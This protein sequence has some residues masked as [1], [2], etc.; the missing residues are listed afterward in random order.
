MSKEYSV[1]EVEEILKEHQ[2]FFESH[3]T[4]GIEFRLSQ[5]QKL[6]DSII[7][8]EGKITEALQQDL[9]KH[10]F[11]TYT[12]EV[13]FVLK[14]IT[15]TMK[16]L[17]SW[18]KTKRVKT[19]LHFQPGKSQIIYEPYGT[20]LII[21]PFN[22]PFQLLIEPLV[23]AIAAGNCAVLKPSE[24]VPNVS[25]V[26]SE[27][28]H[29]T[30]DDNYIRTIEGGIET[31]QSLIHA[32]FDYIFFTGSIPVGKI[33]ME[34]AAKNLVPVTLEL[35]GKSP[36]IVDRTA[37]IKAAAS[38]IMW[39]KCVNSGQT[40]V[41]PDYLLIH[42]SIKDELI[43]EL[44]E[45]INTFYGETVE[46]SKHYGR[47]VT[48]R[49]FNR[50]VDMLEKDKE[51]I[52]FGGN[53][54]PD[55]RYI[56]PTLIEASPDSATMSEEIFGPLLPILTYK[57]IDDAIKIIKNHSKPLA[58]YLFT[59]DQGIEEKVLNEISS[60]GV[61]VNDTLTHLG[62]PELPF[63]GVGASGMGAYHGHYS[64]T[65]FSHEKSVL[66]KN[67]GSNLTLLLPPYT[68]RKLALIKRFLK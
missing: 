56:E 63:G 67:S 66:K 55:T 61:C 8:Y 23:G 39:G 6:K 19:P 10:P 21:S 22:Y 41:A 49:H 40:C 2:A 27:M 25:A 12:T 51:G 48:A 9:G 43:S 14:T 7:K 45:T 30:F 5:L 33:V 32:P 36:V 59:A 50:L 17:K 62:N 64:F 53:T 60:G 18:M 13:G 4:R 46:E 24:L 26:I 16:S 44:K 3:Q 34:A 28:I 15:H 20:V 57:N 58:L 1:V 54:N 38:R 52:I 68:D 42:E 29:S 65:T 35:G 47:I 37:D 11:E 31:N